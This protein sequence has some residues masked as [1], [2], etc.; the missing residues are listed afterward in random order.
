M[1]AAS[2]KAMD[3]N[4]DIKTYGNRLA[5]LP[6]EERKSILAGS[7][8]FNSLCVTCHGPGGKGVAVAGTT[9]LAAPPLQNQKE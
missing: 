7:A 5:N 1:F 9:N 3:R 6:V 8:V 4:T 2:Q